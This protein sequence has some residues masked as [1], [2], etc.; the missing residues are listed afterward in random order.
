MR[1]IGIALHPSIPLNRAF[2]A[3]RIPWI[4]EMIVSAYVRSCITEDSYMGPKRFEFSPAR[5]GIL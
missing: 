3:A 4:Q 5:I 2:A 1:S